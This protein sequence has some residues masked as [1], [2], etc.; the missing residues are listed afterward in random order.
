MHKFSKGL[1]RQ[2][3]RTPNPVG[4][5]GASLAHFFKSVETAASH[6]RA[7]ATAGGLLLV[8]AV[9]WLSLRAGWALGFEYLCL[10][11]CALV[12][13]T[14][15]IAPALA[16]ALAGGVCLYV[17]QA[18]TAGAAP[19]GA[20]LLFDSAVRLVAFAGMSALAGKLGSIARG[21]EQTVE[22]RTAR[23][24][25]EVAQHKETS[26]WLREALELLQELT[27]NIADV[28]WVT[29]PAKTEV[30][31]VSSGFEKV[32]GKSC[33]TF[34]ASPSTWLESIHHE[35]RER[36]TRAVFSKQVRGDYDEEYR[37]VQ[38]DGTVR[39]VHDR[40]FPVKDESGAVYRIVGMAQDITER[41]RAEHLVQ[42]QRD[43]GA[44]LS[45]TSDLNFALERLLDIAMQL[46]GVDCGG[47]YLMDPDTGGLHLRAHR[48]L[49]DGF[50]QR[51]A[52]YRADSREA[53]LAK[54]GTSTYLRRDQIPRTVEVLWGSEGL[55]ALAVVP[56]Q[57]KA[58]VLGML[59]LGSY[60]YD[61]IPARTRVG[62]E[63]IASQV[64]GAIVRIRAEE[65]SRRSE[66][67]L[68]SIVNSA[69]VA[70]L[71]VDAQGMV[72]FEDG[73][74]LGK[75]GIKPGAHVH[76]AA[77][78]V[79]K[80]FP[81]MVENIGRALAGEEFSSVLDFAS[82]VFECQYLP[83][84]DK[85]KKPAGF[86]AVATDVT[87]RL[88]LQR[89][90]LEISDREQARI[91][92]DIHDGLCQQLIGMGF[93][94]HALEKALSGKHEAEAATVRKICALLDEAIGE[95]RR[96]ARGLYPVRLSTHGLWAALEEMAAGVTER[97]NVQCV[98]ESP[99]E[100]PQCDSAAAS[101]L[102]RIAQEAVNNAVKH[103]GAR[104][105]AIELSRGEGEIVLKVTDDGKGL[106]EASVRH[107]GMG[108]H[109]MDYRAR[110]IGG[111]LHL[112]SDAR[113]T[114]VTCRIPQ[115]L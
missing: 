62:V 68:R 35:D 34:Y 98:C 66:A 59:N 27:E 104:R 21:L 80:D 100:A 78:E 96:V 82:A 43:M 4:V 103:S 69:P 89:E 115:I 39:W 29:D 84:R 92:Q 114:V 6:H 32:W 45:S 70:L 33:Q 55:R 111:S 77:A 57:H 1:H 54:S 56:V 44:A 94:A 49:T 40:A 50:V 20:M 15:G 47:V 23:L 16:C 2:S 85:E 83:L 105:I 5:L 24:Q 67:H 72:T 48:G 79:Y 25:K 41:K 22:Q 99:G 91:G 30:E 3:E 112:Q 53:H 38:P 11:A 106:P 73:Q 37:V 52:G 108:L 51:V 9:G 10:F 74:V 76:C 7:L 18:A 12:G 95:S 71:A 75:V 102:Y 42:A 36:V 81:L 8:S 63:V 64:A 93:S 60:R 58:E 87:E 26:E 19:T 86:V 97:H 113:G 109:I 61:E 17:A 90:I 110:L 65:Q 13:W 88:R 107:S 14:A 101:H 31:Y 28:F 46:E